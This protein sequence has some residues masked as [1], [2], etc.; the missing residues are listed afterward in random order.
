M[1]RAAG[2]TPHTQENVQDWLQ[3]NEGDS[4]FQILSLLLFLNKASTMLF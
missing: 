4:G 2:Q 3:L 1:L